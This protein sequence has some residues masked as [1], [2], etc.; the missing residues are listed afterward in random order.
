MAESTTSR[1]V[2]VGAGLLAGLAVAAAVGIVTVNV[3][4]PWEDICAALDPAQA[5][6]EVGSR[7]LVQLQEWLSLA[8]GLVN[9]L[10]PEEREADEA[11]SGLA[12]L[13]EQAKDIAGDAGSG[14]VDIV[15]VPLRALID[16][17]Q[18]VLTSVQAAV[19]AARD[20]MA[21]VDAARC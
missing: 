1:V 6:A 5:L 4:I 13:L 21:S 11:K 8:E 20:V 16:L 7:L 14:V 18:V 12:G 9:N 15:A 3:L 19:D 2:W 17:A 10:G